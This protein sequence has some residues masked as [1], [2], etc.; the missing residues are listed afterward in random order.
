M[1]FRK[2][3]QNERGPPEDHMAV[4]GKEG[5]EGDEEDLEGNSAYGKGLAIAE[6]T[7]CWPGVKG[8]SE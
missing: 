1:Y 4:Y 2:P 3:L 6:R 7:R 5:N 8:M